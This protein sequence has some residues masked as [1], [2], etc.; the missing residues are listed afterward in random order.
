[1]DGAVVLI[2]SALAAE[3]LAGDLIAGTGG[4]RKVRS[5]RTGSGKSGGYRTVHYFGVT[6]FRFFCSL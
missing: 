4:A 3:P 2:V 5:A 6:T 1:M